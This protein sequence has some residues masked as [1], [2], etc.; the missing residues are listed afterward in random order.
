M[1]EPTVIHL[2]PGDVV[3]IGNVGGADDEAYCHTLREIQ[4]WLP[5]AKVVAFL[6]DIDVKLLR[7]I[8]QGDA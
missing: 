6:G 3:L 7:D 4:D 8:E 1:A 5:D 2:V